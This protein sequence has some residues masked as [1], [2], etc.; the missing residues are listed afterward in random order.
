MIARGW[1]DR[2]KR[3]HVRLRGYR[4]KGTRDRREEGRQGSAQDDTL[5]GEKDGRMNGKGREKKG[6]LSKREG[7]TK[8]IE[9]RSGKNE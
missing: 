9:K 4:R 8:G 5:G 6:E 1:K 7:S 3:T 2:T